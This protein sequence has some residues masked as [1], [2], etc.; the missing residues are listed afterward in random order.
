VA[1]DKGVPNA[2][3]PTKQLPEEY[4]IQSTPVL[5]RAHDGVMSPDK[6]KTGERGIGRC[7]WEGSAD[8]ACGKLRPRRP[9]RTRAVSLAGILL[10]VAAMVNPASAQG[11]A[12]GAGGKGAGGAEIAPE[13]RKLYEQGNRVIAVGNYGE[14]RDRYREAFDRARLPKIAVRLGSVELLTG[15]YRDAAEHLSFGLQE[16]EKLSADDRVEIE[17]QLAEAKKKLGTVS[18]EVN[19]AGA[20]VLVDAQHVGITPLSMPVFTETGSRTF[21]AQKSGYISA[22]QVVTVT[23]GSAPMVALRLLPLP[24]RGAEAETAGPASGATAVPKAAATSRSAAIGWGIGLTVVGLG[25]GVGLTFASSA[26]GAAVDKRVSE[27]NTP[28]FQLDCRPKFSSKLNP[29][30]TSL[31]HEFAGM[32]GS[33]EGL[34]LGAIVGYVVGGAALL[35][36]T[37]L[38]VWPRPRGTQTGFRVLPSVGS[39]GGGLLVI[40]SF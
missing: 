12:P 13:V 1:P 21:E 36:T 25:A 34:A 9:R 10:S 17:K 37:A 18:I 38:M 6:M 14:A 28:E 31:C 16:D 5:S 29:A 22:R 20:E 8:D 32:R 15:H 3:I 24:P 40:G 11:T 33:Q 23:A 27:R 26:E 7:L 2:A 39:R 30:D 19:V 35:S 4:E